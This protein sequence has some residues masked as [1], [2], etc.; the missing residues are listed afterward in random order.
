[1]SSDPKIPTGEDLSSNNLISL[2]DD[3]APNPQVENNQHNLAPGPNS[4]QNAANVQ[5]QDQNDQDQ[6]QNVKL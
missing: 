6:N 5:V 3:D 2:D 4:A 1:M